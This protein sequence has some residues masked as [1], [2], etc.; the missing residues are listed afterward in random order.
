MA[1]LQVLLLQIS[2]PL[3]AQGDRICE[4]Q[5]DGASLRA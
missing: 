5:T 4:L 2:A 1:V 3:E